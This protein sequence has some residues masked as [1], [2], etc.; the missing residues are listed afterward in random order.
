MEHEVCPAA[1]DA[2]SP[3]P[4]QPAGRGAGRRDA[5]F[6]LDA[7][8]DALIEVL[9]IVRQRRLALVRGARDIS[10]LRAR[11][12]YRQRNENRKDDLHERPFGLS[13]HDTRR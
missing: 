10:S 2:E 9:F 7:G 11:S 8:C 3:R 12:Q 1:I 13:E 4:F 6:A 5:V